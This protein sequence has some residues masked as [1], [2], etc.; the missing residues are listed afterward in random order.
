MEQELQSSHHYIFLVVILLLPLLAVKLRRRNHGKN[1][2][3]GP[4]RLPVIGSLHHLV[5]ALP[6]RA[7]RD[8]ARRHGP[9][10]LL[11]LGQLPVVVA[12]SP[13]AAREVMRTH[14]A[15]FATRPRTATIREL[16]RDGLGVAFA[17]HGEHWRQ[18]RKLCVT[19]LLSAR[20][21]RSL[22]RGREAEAA[23]LV[24][25]V[26]SLSSA[27]APP[28]PVNVSALLAT[29]VTD[30]IVRAVV[31]DRISDRDAFL[32][33]LDE[34]VKVAA[35]FSL[36][37]VFP[38][39]RLARAFSG[40]ARRAQAHH[41]EM[42][43]LMDGVIEEHR[44]RRAAGAGNEEEDLLDVLLR[45]QKEGSL[46][47]PLDMGTIR[48][49]IIDLFGAG[50]ETTA[51]T[52]QWAMAELVRHPAALRKAQAEVRCVLAGESRVAEDV[53]PELRYLQLVM[54]ETLR[55]H[56]AVP[57]LLPRECQEE[58]RGVLGYD[59]P[60]GAMVLVN[61]WAIGRDAAIWGPD[62]EE[63]QPERFE[64]GGAGAEVNFRGTDFEFVPFGAGR[65]ICPGIALGLAVMEL[66]LASLLF[67][68]D[69]ELPGGA[70]PEELDMAEGLGITARR[71]SDLWL[72]AT[73]RVPVP[74]I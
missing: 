42:T 74:N 25:S 68:F 26:A 72:Q 14:D 73:V 46:H 18:L 2:P 44:Q 24:A 48:A 54:K 55:L 41:R 45:V 47:V 65:R 50:S 52:L 40:A 64:G 3:P 8:L 31:G 28:K 4:W 17:P 33:K 9:L 43:R 34:G 58:T 69:W 66:G 1:P 56:A 63:F 71:K 10:M 20:R 61:A 16:T 51:T 19:E 35:G 23:N 6:H 32:E 5:G 62:A 59:V 12:S 67:H 57:L 53:L 11:R 36:A 7:M 27:P 38:S 22:R 29:Y 37:D 15:A 70:A 13:D 39:S 60:G 49:V 30:A 21:V